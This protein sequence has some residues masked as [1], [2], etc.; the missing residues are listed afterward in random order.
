MPAKG[1]DTSMNTSIFLAKLMGP[2][3]LVAG[4]GLFANAAAYKAMAKEFL[5]SPALIYLSGL[6]T[7]ATGVAVVLTHNVWVANW[8]VIITLF[9]WAASI[10]GAA[11]IAL[12][13]KIRSIGES[14]IDKPMVMNIGGGVWLVFGALL[15]YFGYLR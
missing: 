2:V 10:G 11:R 13:D 15:C 4:I 9:G 14:M 7:M 8:P 5:R 6:L 3:M 12:P 1:Q